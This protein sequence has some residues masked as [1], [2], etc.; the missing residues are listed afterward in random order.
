MPRLSLGLGMQSTRKVGGGS[1]PKPTAVLI[2][3]AGEMTSNG[4]YVWD[5]VT[6]V[7]GERYYQTVSNSI[8]WL[9]SESYW[10]I[11]DIIFDNNTYRSSDLITWVAINGSAGPTP[12]G[13]LSYS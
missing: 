9:S 4:N 7:N 13:T 3:G 5:G 12:T 2:S 10:F 1:A 8:F 11:E 6:L